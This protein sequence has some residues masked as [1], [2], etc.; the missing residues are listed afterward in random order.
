MR[1]IRI[2]FLVLV[3]IVLVTIALAN[4]GTIAVKALP[5]ELNAYLGLPTTYEVPLYVVL[6]GGVALGLLIGFVWEWL[7]EHKIRVEARHQ[8]RERERLEREVKGLKA[9]GGEGA[10][11]VLALL[12]TGAATR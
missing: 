4:R 7:R 12:D 6:F 10:D 3:A 1:F 8:R 2:L 5:D 11:D 9:R